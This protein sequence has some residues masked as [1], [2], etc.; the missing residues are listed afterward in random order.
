[1]ENLIKNSQN[2]IKKLKIENKR[3]LFDLID[4][5][6]K[7]VG[8]I[9]QRGTGKTTIM[10][11][12]LQEQKEKS[13]L[14]YFSADDIY[15]LENSLKKTV[16]TLYYDYGIK[17]FCIDEIHKYKNWNQELKNIYD[18]LPDSQVIFSGSSALDIVKESFDLSRRAILY[19]LYGLSFREFILFRTGEDLKKISLDDL[20]KKYKKL[21]LEIS[22]KVDVLKLFQEYL[23]I[24]YFP[25][26][27]EGKKE[28]LYMKFENTFNKI[29]F[30]D[31]SNLEN[32][33]TANLLV[34]KRILNFLASVSP[35]QINIHRM[36]LNLGVAFET[37]ENYVDILYRVSLVRYLL[38]DK[39]GYKLIRKSE[40]IFLDNT[41]FYFYLQSK[42]GLENDS[43]TIRELFVL[44]QLQNVN[45]KIYASPK[46]GDFLLKNGKEKIILEVGGK[47]KDFKQISKIKSSFLVLDDM[48]VATDSKIPLYLFGFLY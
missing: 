21:S 32:I 6:Q 41:N 45:A 42:L 20:I 2:L 46:V 34:F 12:F 15:F 19:N 24:G 17:I 3:Y 13:H 37:V 11:Q 38:K 26:F 18:L 1:M 31:I 28:Q 22:N 36:A 10:L 44:N 23:Q 27:L 4:F 35:G 5:S 40:K 7:L 25:Y 9:G 48:R 16:E 43:G 30:E 29:I 33:K 39:H 8:I 14:I 47:S